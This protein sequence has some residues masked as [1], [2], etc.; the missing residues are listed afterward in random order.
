LNKKKKIK[1]EKYL[2]AEQRKQLDEQLAEEARKRE[3]ERLD[4]WR[5]RGLMDMMGGVLQI[6]KEDELKKDIPVPAFVAEK[7]QEDW[8]SDEKAQYQIYEAKVKELNEERT[9]L[10]KVQPRDKEEEELYRKFKSQK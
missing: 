7:A 4:N 6:R 10:K 9:K 3:I 8:T 2:T 1:V 5:E